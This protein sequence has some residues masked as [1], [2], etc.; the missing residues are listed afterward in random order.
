MDRLGPAGCRREFDSLKA[1]LQEN[2][3]EL[4][5]FDKAKATA[6]VVKTGIIVKLDDWT[7][8]VG[9]MLRLAIRT[10]ETGREP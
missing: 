1:R 4:S 10:A 2:Y 9:S 6:L 8:P 7:D 3:N 5:L